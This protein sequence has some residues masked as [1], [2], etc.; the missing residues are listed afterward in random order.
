MKQLL[1]YNTAL[2]D[3]DMNTVQAWLVSQP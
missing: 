1:I 3:E 2:N